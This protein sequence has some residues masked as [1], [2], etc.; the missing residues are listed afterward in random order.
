MVKQPVDTEFKLEGI[1]SFRLTCFDFVGH[2]Q[3]SLEI[4]SYDLDSALLDQQPFLS[5]AKRL[6]LRSRFCQVRI[7]LQNN[8]IAQK[9]GHRLIELVRNMPSSMEI[10]RPGSDHIEHLENFIIV[11]QSSYIRWNRSTRYQGFGASHYRLK[12]QRLSEF[13]NEIWQCS[14]PETDLRRLYI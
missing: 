12:A 11:D 3:K 8:G 5:A 6:G 13:F 14:E 9:Q 10:R 1:E 4:L 2:A 7:L